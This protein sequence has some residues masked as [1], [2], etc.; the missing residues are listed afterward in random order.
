MKN[1]INKQ[2]IHT[3]NRIFR[4]LG[5]WA[6]VCWGCSGEKAGPAP[7][8]FIQLDAIRVDGIASGYSYQNVKSRPDIELRFS[9]PVNKATA[10]SQI[11][12]SRSDGAATPFTVTFSRSDSMLTVSP[13][14]RLR[15][16]DQFELSISSGLSGTDGAAL[17]VPVKVSLTSGLDSTD[18]FARIAPDD[19]LELVQKQT[20]RYFWDHAHPVSGMARERFGSGNL[21]TTG[22]TGFG[23]MSVLVAIE[24]NF[25][26][27][28]QGMD[29][30]SQIVEFLSEKTTRYHGAFAHWIDGNSGQTIAFSAYDNGADL[31]ETSL[32]MQG[33]LTARQYFDVNN[34]AE[35]ALRDAINKLWQEVEWAWFEKGESNGLYWHWSPEH[36]WRMNL[37]ITGWNEALITYVLGAG[38]TSHAISRD[39][40][41]NGWKGGAHYLNNQFYYGYRLPLGEDYG[42]P[43]FLS[44][45]SFLGIDP[46]G[47]SDGATDYLVQNTHHT[48]INRSYCMANPKSFTGYSQA[49]WGL[50]ASDIPGGYTA[51]SPTHDNGTITP[52]AALSAFPYTPVE[53]MQALEFFYY[54]LGDRLWTDHGFRD[55]FNPSAQWFADSHLAIDQGPIIVMI[56]NYRSGLLWNLFMS[57]PEVKLGLNKLGFSKK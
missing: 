35:S 50:T 53:S 2:S 7:N 57:C 47:L 14:N 27:R 36:E 44:Q 18:K 8:R 4:Y 37:R 52:T 3:R 5:L 33:L 25:I 30:I 28:S 29:R 26:S 23:V 40:Y 6:W 31:V 51:N 24:R 12:L 48:L 49:C 41:E 20:F 9:A 46:R 32:L 19:L 10:A 39:A 55:A 54:K 21:V 16:Y 17:Q 45:Y 11:T 1:A 13:E 15:S 56:E 42:G 43:L 34:Q 22:G 38:S